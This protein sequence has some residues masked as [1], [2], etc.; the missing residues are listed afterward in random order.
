M[1]PL[2][3]VVSYGQVAGPGT[4]LLTQPSRA[5]ATAVQ[6]AGLTVSDLEVVEVNEAF[7]AVVVA[8]AR[9]LSIPEEIVNPNGGAIALGHPTRHVRCPAGPHAYVT[10]C[11]TAGRPHRRRRAVRRRGPGRRRRTQVLRLMSAAVTTERVGKV[12]VMRLDRPPVNALSIGLLAELGRGGR[13]DGCRP[14]P[15]RWSSRGSDRIFSAGADVTEFGGGASG[16]RW[17]GAFA[18]VLDAIASLPRATVAAI[19]GRRLRRWSRAGS[20]VRFSGRGQLGRGSA[21]RRS[22]WASSRAEV[23]PSDW[24][25]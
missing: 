2:A 21:S 1:S 24:P 5:I 20:G 16:P 11:I 3:E 6:R 22:C 18:E 7:A 10:S 4:S 9:D 13:G 23:G 14:R 8:S 19:C 25:G 17:P 12:A 15:G